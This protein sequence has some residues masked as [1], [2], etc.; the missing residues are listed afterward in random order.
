MKKIDALYTEHPFYGARKLSHKLAQDGLLVSRKKIRRMMKAMG[1]EAIYAQPK[2]QHTCSDKQHKKYPYLLRNMKISFPNQ[3]WAVDITYIP[4]KRGFM[5]LVA[6]IDWHS[7]YL[8]HYELSNSLEVTFCL[9]ALS[10]ALEGAIP[11]VVNTDQGS[12]FTSTEWI[13]ALESRN[14]LVSMDGKGRAI[15]NIAI[16]RFFRS[17]K[18][19]CIYLNPVNSVRELTPIV[20]NYIDFY[21]NKRPH[22]GLSYR[23]PAE[24]YYQKK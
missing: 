16:E 18:Y 10:R 22:Q 17:L 21:N 11:K 15:D 2:G 9:E 19:E 23:T 13:H 1:L 3:V 20:K 12:Q 7:R 4:T 5:Y 8:L 14:I 6:I 24:V